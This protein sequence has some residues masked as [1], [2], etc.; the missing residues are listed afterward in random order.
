MAA[1]RFEVHYSVPRCLLRFYDRFVAAGL[2]GEGLQAWFE[3][4]V[5]A[6]RYRVDPDVSR[7]E[8]ESLVEDSAS[9]VS[10]VAHRAGHS[11]GGDLSA[12]AAA[13]ACAQCPSTV[14]AGSCSW[15]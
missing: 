5:E 3:W 7:Q 14:I 4:E 11:R 8:L 13:G 10:D 6:F 9:L 1:C 15:Q 12:G 2:D